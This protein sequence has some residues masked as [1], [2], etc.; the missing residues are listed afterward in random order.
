MGQLWVQT[1]NNACVGHIKRKLP[2]TTGAAGSRYYNN[3]YDSDNGDNNGDKGAYYRAEYYGRS[4]SS[5]DD[6]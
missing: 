5:S 1:K 2:I 4:T 3:T 6:K